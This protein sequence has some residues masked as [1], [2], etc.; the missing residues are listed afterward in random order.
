MA[1]GNFRFDTF[2]CIPTFMCNKSADLGII[3]GSFNIANPLPAKSH[4]H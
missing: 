2:V 1:I 4:I 3:L